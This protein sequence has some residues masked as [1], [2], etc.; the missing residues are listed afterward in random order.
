MTKLYAIF[1]FT[2]HAL[3][4]G[5]LAFSGSASCS[6]QNTVKADD[7]PVVWV[8][9]TG[10]TIS[11]KGTSST[12]FTE[13]KAGSLLGKEIVDGFRRFDGTPT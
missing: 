9:S 6:A 11:G 13:Y 10:G 12:S 8:L 5:F 1:R 4:Y 2:L 7:L 3:V